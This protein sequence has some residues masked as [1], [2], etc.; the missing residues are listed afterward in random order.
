MFD[1]KNKFF[2]KLLQ[3]HNKTLKNIIKNIINIFLFDQFSFNRQFENERN[4]NNKN[5]SQSQSQSQLMNFEIF[6]YAFDDFNNNFQKQN[7]RQ[8]IATNDIKNINI[9]L[10]YYKSLLK[11]YIF[12]DCTNFVALKKNKNQII[13]ENEKKRKKK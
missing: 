7:N 9:D 10:N 3:N 6:F 12:Q 8:Y 5:L 1:F 13:R 11:N 4:I 2:A